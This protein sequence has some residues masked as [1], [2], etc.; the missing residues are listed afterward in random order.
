MNN[1]RPLTEMITDNR[2]KVF[3]DPGTASISEQDGFFDKTE[4]E[5]R[6][7]SGQKDLVRRRSLPTRR[8]PSEGG[9]YMGLWAALIGVGAGLATIY[10]LDPDRGGRRRPSSAKNQQFSQ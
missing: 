6:L 5:S 2:D 4:R 10:F 9:G 3:G 7:R 8:S 1:E